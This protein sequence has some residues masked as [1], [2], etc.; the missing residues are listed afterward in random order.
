MTD[1][2]TDTLQVLSV[3]LHYPDE[4]LLNG[5]EEIESLA[6]NLPFSET[7]SAIKA[8]ISD[9]KTQPL[10][11]VQERY[12]A[13]FDMDPAT[14]LNVTYHAFG[15]NEKRAAALAYLQHNYEQAGWARVTG[16]LPDYLPLMLEFLSVCAD[17]RHAQP[18]W[19]CLQGMPPLVAR[20]EEKAP[21]Y[22]ALLQPIVRMAVECS[23]SVDNGGHPP[24]ANA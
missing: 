19:Q 2:H 6:A 18:V 13:V 14:T 24:E 1:H 10:I 7:E 8:F 17:P 20:L 21:V 3:L 16:E 9:L 22:A 4:D 5:L 15:D 11:G 12:T 23:A